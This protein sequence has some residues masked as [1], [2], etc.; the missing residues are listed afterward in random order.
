MHVAGLKPLYLNPSSIDAS[1][2]AHER[3]VLKEAAAGSGKPAAVVDKMVEGRLKKWY[4]EVRFR[5]QA[6]DHLLCLGVKS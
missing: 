4:Q 6:G 1:H 5:D 3:Q 2:L